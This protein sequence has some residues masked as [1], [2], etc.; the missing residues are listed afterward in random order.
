[1]TTIRFVHDI[2][3]L[4]S[5]LETIA[6]QVRPRAAALVARKV[7]HGREVARGIAREASGPHGTNY[8]KRITSE[9]TGDLQGEIGPTG[10]VEGR[11]VGAGWRHGENTDM[12]RTADIIGPSL[13]A[14]AGDMAA[15]LF[16]PGT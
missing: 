16:W 10:E 7:N 13:A 15:D 3:D 5:D 4:V 8:Y 11:A 9:M 12:A 1:V 6:G 14:D 2:G